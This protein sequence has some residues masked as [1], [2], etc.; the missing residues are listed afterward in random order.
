MISQIHTYIFELLP[1][2]NDPNL[3]H[4]IK[5]PPKQQTTAETFNIA[6]NIARPAC[7]RQNFV[8]VTLLRPIRGRFNDHT[9]LDSHWESGPVNGRR[10]TRGPQHHYKWS[11][12]SRYYYIMC[13]VCVFYGE[14]IVM[15]AEMTLW[16]IVHGDAFGRCRLRLLRKFCWLFRFDIWKLKLRVFF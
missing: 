16:L 15:N 13:V 1:Q 14:C 5:A 2:S 9:Q 11:L 10:R 7:E 8:K 12:L 6:N 3:N 4:H